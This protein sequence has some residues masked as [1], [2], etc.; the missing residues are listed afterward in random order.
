M[1]RKINNWL[2]ITLLCCSLNSWSQSTTNYTFS[3]A[4]DAS[5]TDMSTGTTQLVAPNTDGLGTGIFSSVNDIGFTFYFM[6]TAYTN[7]VVT[8]D[9]VIRLGNSLSGIN[10]TPEVNFA[11]PRIIPFAADMYVGSNGKVHYKV[12]GTAPNRVLIVEWKNLQIAFPATTPVAGNSTFQARLYESTGV[13]E[14]IY[15]YMYITR[16][17]PFGTCATPTNNDFGGIGFCTANAN[18][19]LIYKTTNFTGANVGTTVPATLILNSTIECPPMANNVE[20]T[21]LSSS[22]DGA[23]RIYSFTP[24]TAPN[25][26]S[27]LTFSG[28]SQ[29]SITLNWTDNSSNETHFHVYRSE[30]GGLT[31]DLVKIVTA[32]SITSGPITGLPSK[33]Y[34]WRVYAVNEGACSTALDGSCSTLAAGDIH[35]TA[36][37]GLWSQ[38]ATWVGGVLP[39]STDNVTISDGATVIIDDNFAVCNNLTV[40]EGT[41]GN[42]SFIGATANATLTCDGDVTVT[43]NGT[44]DVTAGAT[45]GTRKLI[46]GN[47]SLAN[48]NL[49]VNGIFDMNCAGANSNADVEFRGTSDGIVSGTGG[50]CDFYSITINK[51]TSIDGIIDFQR[52]FTI[53][54][55]AVAGSRLVISNGTLKLSAACTLEPYFG[56]QT[57]L[58]STAKIWLN[59]TNAVLRCVGSGTITGAGDLTINGT[60]TVTSGT[61]S[62]G[63][64]NNTMN[65]SATGTV[66]L[67]GNTGTINMY[68]R[69]S[70]VNSSHLNIF[71]GNFNLDPQA[72]NNLSA[73]NVFDLGTTAYVN[74]TGGTLTFIDPANFNT[75]DFAITASGGEQNKNLRGI[76]LSF[77]DGIS[78]SPGNATSTGFTLRIPT[79]YGLALGNIIVNNPAGANRITKFSLVS[80][81]YIE[82]NNV[83]VSAGTLNQNTTTEVRGDIINNGT[84]NYATATT[85]RLVGTSLQ[86]YSGT[87]TQSATNNL[88]L[89][90]RNASGFTLNASYKVYG[91]TMTT[92]N[93]NTS[94][95]NSL[96]VTGATAAVVTGGSTTSFVNG[97]LLRNL[98][99]T[100]GTF[101]FP[102]GKS[103]YTPFELR[104]ARANAGTITVT[105]EVFDADCGG[106]FSTAGYDRSTS[107][108]WL[109]S[110]TGALQ[111][112]SSPVVRV[113]E[114][115]PTTGMHIGQS[116][117]LTGVYTD[118]FS[119]AASNYVETQTQPS[120]NL[121]LN[122]FCLA[123]PG[124]FKDTVYVGTGQPFLSYTKAGG[125]FEAINA[126]GLK[127]NLVAMTTSDITNEDGVNAL[128]A[129]AELNGSGYTFKIQSNT[130][131]SRLISGTGAGGVFRLNGADRVSFNG[132]YNGAGS[133][134]TFRCTSNNPVFT[135][136]NDAT[137][138]TL[139]YI[140]IE[141]PNTVATS[142]SILFSTTTGTSGNDFNVISNC[143]IRDR[144]DIAGVPVNAITS[145]GTAA[146]TN[147]N[148]IITNCNI[149]NFTSRGLFLSTNGGS[150]W[151]IS[152]NSFYQTSARNTDQ[153]SIDIQTGNGDIIEN[154]FIGGNAPSCGGT[155][156]SNTG[157]VGIRGIRIN[158]T[159]GA[160]TSVQNNTISNFSMSADNGSTLFTG[161]DIISTNSG[162]VNIGT[163]TGNTIGS[164]T[165]ANDIYIAARNPVMGINSVSVASVSIWNNTIANINNYSIN[166]LAAVRGLVHTGT[167]SANIAYNSIFNLSTTSTKVAAGP[168]YAAQGIYYGGSG[169]G[170][171]TQNTIY[172][173]ASLNN[174][175]IASTSAGI[176]LNSAANPVINRNKIWGISNAAIPVGAT[177]PN[178]IGINIISPTAGSTVEVRL[179]SISIGDAQ[180]TNTQ[181]CGLWLS[182]NTTAYTANVNYNSV[183]IGGS[184]V[185]TR[186]SY[187]FLRGSAVTNATVNMQNN[188]FANNR[189]GGTGKHYAIANTGASPATGWPTSASNYNLL[190]TSSSATLGLWNATD[191]NFTGWKTNSSC[192]NQ[193]LAA[194]ATAGVSDADNINLSNLFTNTANGDLHIQTNKAEG[195]FCNGKGTQTSIANDIDNDT[196][197]TLVSS[198][199][200][201]IGADEFNTT[202]DP[203]IASVSGTISDGSTT[204][205]SLGGKTQ[206]LILWHGANFPTTI[207]LK[208]W[209][210]KDPA[211][212][213][214]FGSPYPALV[215]A[216]YSNCYWTIDATGGTITDYT[217][218]LTLNYDDPLL[219]TLND[220][221][222]MN[223]GKIPF[224]FPT[225][226]SPADYSDWGVYVP[227]V[228]TTNKTVS[229]NGI[230]GFSDFCLLK[231]TTVPLPIELLSFTATYN[232]GDVLVNWTTSSE[233]NNDYFTV[234]KSQDATMFIGFDNIKGAGNS[235]TVLNYSTIDKEP[236]PGTSYYRLKQTDF[237]GKFTLSKIVAVNITR[238]ASQSAFDVFPNPVDKENN[239]S[240]KISD[241]DSESEVLVVV[242]NLLGEELYSKVIMTDFSG[243]AITA[244]DLENRLPSGTYLIV[245][246]SLNQTFNKYLII[247]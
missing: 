199:G 215:G 27:N 185:G 123:A 205:Y 218:D 79:L 4:T 58:G 51:G 206:A 52:T 43:N 94:A 22:T 244:I 147:S 45:G 32:N 213:D 54:S 59:H 78:S 9:G 186:N 7:F 200:V 67:N 246:T 156:W 219:Y 81:S 189:S 21:G 208:Y 20:L 100:S 212:T 247:K 30:D 140:T 113:Y 33:N 210:Q 170:F 193:S 101:S 50:T 96:T 192:D 233:T 152:N 12:T 121:A 31:Y 149:F 110:T 11:E 227:T 167:G 194:I 148:N 105:A 26:P 198:G 164:T 175:N 85:M 173:I 6:S 91:L 89:D 116:T 174:G 53:S 10:R 64:G 133:Y 172:N 181:F 187:A 153:C 15:G 220:P 120:L 159:A 226:A 8:E 109:A 223:I 28:V 216:K 112:A 139:Q 125:L 195:W 231:G 111:A 77:G 165:N 134:L 234:E 202:V 239:P 108:Y 183:Y 144:S 141:S 25:A 157:N 240:V 107:R 76:T 29:T 138:D 241:F 188:I 169:S 132:Q 97:P 171:I 16:S 42:L 55:P 128:N 127:G 72:G 1:E 49:A 196:R 235:H 66:E 3:T 161:I 24:R 115:N 48:A 237:D 160:A 118:I 57:I 23:R 222:E 86:T 145:V 155:A 191:Y 14:F 179:N 197:N 19:S 236:Y 209:S 225:A 204:T 84:L 162:P 190:V 44:F 126:R 35:S 168:D 230:I 214:G 102:V 217:Y 73:G 13:I 17:N 39:I 103:T 131:T 36:T 151:S 37:G 83:T 74:F 104:S 106:T 40:G 211:L 34:L 99:T 166:A 69:A 184:P 41:S 98:G 142:G 92:G 176:T 87:G 221:L 70:F 238:P 178:A 88:T 228:N 46:L 93:I 135:Y 95:V 80:G 65:V 130:T 154:N 129:W 90:M 143:S 82:F 56:T 243:N 117:T 5:L 61:F 180:N 242:R 63:S 62:Y 163:V 158:T 245:G 232:N 150:G 60:L 136:L 124:Y 224:I 229:R 137:Y 47:R 114:A 201:D 68:G 2:I 38:T 182:S 75:Y 146:K 71:D 203:I 122:Y 18:N 207:S 177:I 119:L